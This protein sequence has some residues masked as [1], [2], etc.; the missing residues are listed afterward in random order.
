MLRIFTVL[1]TLT[2]PLFTHAGVS[3]WTD[4]QDYNGHIR[5]PVT[6]AGIEGYGILDTGAA[7][8]AINKSFLIK[9]QLT[10]KKGQEIHIKGVHG[11]VKTKV[12]KN[13][14]VDIFGYPIPFKEMVPL[15][16]GRHENIVLLG[17]SFFKLFVFQIDYPNQRLRIMTR[18]SLDMDTLENIKMRL[19][20]QSGIPIVTVSIGNGKKLRLLLDTG[21]SGGILMPRKVAKRLDLLDKYPQEQSLSGGV[22]KTVVADN[23]VLPELKFGPYTLENVSMVVPVKGSGSK[24]FERKV[25]TGTRIAK[26]N[27]DGILGYDVLK[28]FVLTI[29]YKT[30]DMHVGT[31]EN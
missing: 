14:T 28:H 17:S 9:H 22:T 20:P 3:E 26:R 10:Y 18:D 30:G 13:I 24:M 23:F 1:L 8:N 4:F 12:L 27:P 25:V 19:D 21:N 29:D 31:P 5:I 11:K 6:V 15:S 16:I 2:L 7:V